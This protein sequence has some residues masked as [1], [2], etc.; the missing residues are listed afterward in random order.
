MRFLSCPAIFW[1]TSEHVLQHTDQPLRGGIG[2]GVTKCNV[3]LNS[4]GVSFPVI[5]A[6]WVD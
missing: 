3:A 5:A 6:R 4:L 1:R 2:S